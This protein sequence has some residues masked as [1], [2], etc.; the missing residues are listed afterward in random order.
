MGFLRRLAL[1]SLSHFN[2]KINH[3]TDDSTGNSTSTKREMLT[4][5]FS[6]ITARIC[7]TRAS[8]AGVTGA[9]RS[10][11]YPPRRGRGDR[12]RGRLPRGSTSRRGALSRTRAACSTHAARE[13]SHPAG[14]VR[15]LRIMKLCTNIPHESLGREELL[16]RAPY[17]TRVPSSPTVSDQYHPPAGRVALSLTQGFR[18]KRRVPQQ[19]KGMAN[20]GIPTPGRSVVAAPTRL[21]ARSPRTD[22]RRWRQETRDWTTV[23]MASRANRSATLSNPNGLTQA[24]HL[25][26]LVA[27]SRHQ[28]TRR[29]NHNASCFRHPLTQARTRC[30]ARRRLQCLPITPSLPPSC[31]RIVSSHQS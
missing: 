24:I 28:A 23:S 14:T 3:F 13:C 2:D 1:S 16:S 8:Q 27:P 25:A 17:H 30:C 31:D 9:Q 10:R 22:S 15:P 4:K 20:S 7:D 21:R 11:H 26:P 29:R 6:T 12:G 18:T 5:V 19:A